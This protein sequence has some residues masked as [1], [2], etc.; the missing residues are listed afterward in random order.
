[1]QKKDFK[2]GIYLITS[3]V[4]SLGL[5][6]SFQSLLAVWQAPGATPP[7]GNTQAPIYN[8][9]SVDQTIND[10][11]GS[12]GGLTVLGGVSTPN[13][14]VQG[15]ISGDGDNEGISIDSNGNVGIGMDSLVDSLNVAGNAR[16]MGNIMVYPENISDNLKLEING[17][18][19]S[20]SYWLA[21]R[22][23]HN[24]HWDRNSL[25]GR[26]RL[27]RLGTGGNL[28]LYNPTIAMNDIKIKLHT[29]GNSYFNGGNVGI[30]TISP[31]AKLSVSFS[32]NDMLNVY[33]P[34][35]NT[36]A[37]Q[38]TLDNHSIGTYGGDT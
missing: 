17:G 3:I 13:L 35:N 24:F 18:G 29:S 6:I 1:M 31:K 9:S 28:D 12:G 2:L 38:T 22:W 30:G 7:N 37:I 4:L 5:S 25:S 11:S 20:N 23:G 27:M 26:V 34:A 15:W 10:V 8:T 14:A 16:V 21:N 36:L 32:N 33:S 19:T